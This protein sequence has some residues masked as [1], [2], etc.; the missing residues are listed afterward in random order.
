MKTLILTPLLTLALIAGGAYLA[1]QYLRDEADKGTITAQQFAKVRTGMPR[2][3]VEELLDGKPGYRR[4]EGGVLG[5]WAAEALSRTGEPEG[6]DCA[7]YVDAGK[8]SLFR[9]CFGPRGRV[10]TRDVYDT[11]VSPTP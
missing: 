8:V 3:R 2:A 1:Y 6:A 5:N 9:V 7:Y 4:D 11:R 10:V